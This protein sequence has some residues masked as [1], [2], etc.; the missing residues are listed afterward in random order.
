[1]GA[2]KEI[3]LIIDIARGGGGGLREVCFLVPY[4]AGKVGVFVKQEAMLQMKG[5]LSTVHEVSWAH[6]VPRALKSSIMANSVSSGIVHT[7]HSNV[8]M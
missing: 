4:P 6:F 7:N 2:Y 1:M 8:P 5:K 3:L